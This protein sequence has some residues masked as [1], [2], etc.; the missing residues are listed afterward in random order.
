MIEIYYNNKLLALNIEPPQVSDLE[1]WNIVM[2]Y[3]GNPEIVQLLDIFTK[4]DTVEKVFL[5][6]EDFE[7]LQ[8]DFFASV[9]LIEA[10]GGIVKN[11]NGEILFIKRLGKWDLPKGKVENNES[12]EESALRE[13][14]EECGIKSLTLNKKINSTYHLY[15]LKDDLI[16]KK[17]HWFWVDFNSDDLK[18]IPQIEENI[19]DATWKKKDSISEIKENTY[20]GIIALLNSVGL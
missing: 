10:A 6:C 14:A 19:T 20:P 8:T 13:I 1:N 17:S 5:W 7:K 16:L 9:T 2:H 18:L 12:I 15:F 3:S 4:I 11:K